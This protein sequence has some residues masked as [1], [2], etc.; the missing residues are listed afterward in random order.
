MLKTHLK[1][2]VCF[3]ASCALLACGLEALIATKAVAG[4]STGAAIQQMVVSEEACTDW[5]VRESQDKVPAPDYTLALNLNFNRCDEVGGLGMSA[6]CGEVA[7]S[8][9][10]I[11][12]VLLSRPPP[13][14]L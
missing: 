4:I 13:T 10:G 11:F 1:L 6:G 12:P 9:G 14:T 8:T 2:V 5:L 3:F 7:Q